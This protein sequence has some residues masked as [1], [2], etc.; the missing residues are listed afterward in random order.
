MVIRVSDA[1]ILDAT[2]ASIR[3]HGVHGSTTREIA[4]LAGV[5]EVT[6]FRRFGDKR[7]LVRAAV[8]DAIARQ[9]AGEFV[10]TGDV[11][12]DLFEIVR[13]YTAAFDPARGIALALVTEASRHPDLVDL[14]AEPVAVFGRAAEVI[15][16]HQERGELI[17]EPVAD[18]LAALVGP[19]LFSTLGRTLDSA[20]PSRSTDS[21]DGTPDR[22]VER[23]LR[24]HG[25][26]AA[27]ERA[28]I[29]DL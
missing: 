17:A 16:Y 1:Q 22:V 7:Q 15:R 26:E 24:G 27:D 3:I 25:N 5:N 2:V 10:P 12:M 28:P 4:R 20:S 21:G 6:L 29:S 18:A 14:L 23:F 9:G 13:F 19:L 11:R 8:H